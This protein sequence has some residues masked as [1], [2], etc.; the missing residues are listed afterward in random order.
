NGCTGQ[1][2]S[3][4]LRWTA[5]PNRTQA[6]ALI[7][8]D[9]DAKAPGGWYHWLVV[10][11]PASQRTLGRDAGQKNGPALPPGALQTAISFGQP[12]Y[13]GPC[14][15]VGSGPHHYHFTLYA[16]KAPLDVTAT[17]KPGQVEAAA[18]AASLGTAELV[19]T[20][21]R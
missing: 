17:D 4:E 10:N 6:L 3:P 11:I 16:L 8:H 19:G 18:K 2:S 12:G 21:E 15:P 14:P 9:P 13:G 7:V 5:L 20:F 1:N